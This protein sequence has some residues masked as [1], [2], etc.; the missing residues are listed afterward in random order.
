[1]IAGYGDTGFGDTGVDP[2]ASEPFIKRA[3]L[4]RFEEI[5]DDSEVEIGFDF[6][7]GEEAHNAFPFI[8]VESDLG[9]GKDEVLTSH[10][11]SGGPAF[12]DGAIAGVNAFNAWL[13]AADFNDEFDQSWGEVG[14]ATRVSS[15]REF[16]VNATD[17]EAVFVPE[18]DSFLPLAM[19]VSLA[20]AFSRRPTVDGT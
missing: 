20:L 5:F 14:F 8:G 16:I 18:S 12:V 4:N 9:F 1:M 10:G 15:F 13:T 7:S 6:D 3:G 17:G 19:M 2:V 11:D